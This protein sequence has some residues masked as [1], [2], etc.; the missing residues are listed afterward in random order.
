MLLQGGTSSFSFFYNWLK[1]AGVWGGGCR[2][3]V[4]DWFTLGIGADVRRGARGSFKSYKFTCAL[5]GGLLG[6]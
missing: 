3:A 1:S 6:S 4:G 2:T 5:S